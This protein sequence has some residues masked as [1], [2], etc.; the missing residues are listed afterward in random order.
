MALV[1]VTCGTNAG[2]VAVDCDVHG[3]QRHCLG[4]S[5]FVILAVTLN[6]DK[7]SRSVPRGGGDSIHE[8]DHYSS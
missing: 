1:P 3:S 5:L 6:V 4:H 2:A 7:T 8:T